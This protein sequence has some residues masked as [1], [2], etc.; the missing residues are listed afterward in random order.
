M[1]TYVTVKIPSELAARLDGLA[2]DLGYHSRAE[3]VNDAVRRFIDERKRL[4]TL[5]AS[6]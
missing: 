6:N 5:A 4:E 1:S 3:I 2:T